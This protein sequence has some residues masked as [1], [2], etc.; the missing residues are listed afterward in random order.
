MDVLVCPAQKSRWRCRS[1]AGRKLERSKVAGV[2]ST[3]TSGK[4]YARRGS[5]N[6]VAGGGSE[7]WLLA[8]CYAIAE[9]GGFV[10]SALYRERLLEDVLR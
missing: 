10:G 8:C 4:D 5:K 3:A 2:G 9:K 1:R 6:A 7:P